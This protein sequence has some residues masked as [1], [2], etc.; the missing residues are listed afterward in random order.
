MNQ[1]VVTLVVILLPGIFATAI[2][3][4]IA[5]HS[6][7]G[8]F[9]YTLYSII[10]G[11]ISY[12]TFQIVSFIPDINLSLQESAFIITFNPEPLKVWTALLNGGENGTP[13]I[14]YI[15][16]IG[17]FVCSVFVAFAAAAVINYKILNKIAKKLKISTKYGDENLFSYYL[18]LDEVRWVYVRD[19]A[20]NLTYKGEIVMHSENSGIQELVLS[21]VDVYDYKDSEH[22]YCIA[23][24]YLCKKIGELTIEAAINTDIGE[25]NERKENTD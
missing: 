21:D 24:I 6:Q 19:M 16:I 14:P 8:W 4:K 18:N 22:L 10:L 3:D 1:L 13:A 11:W 12:V 15:E 7:W 2:C 20:S 5:R 25:D 9:K 23:S 17:S